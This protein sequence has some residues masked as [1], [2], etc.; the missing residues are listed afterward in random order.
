MKV[1]STARHV[2]HNKV[3]VI[4][5]E[6]Y[7]KIL[8]GWD[9]NKIYILIPLRLSTDVSKTDSIGPTLTPKD[10]QVFVSVITIRF[11]DVELRICSTIQKL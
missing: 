4:C 9:G 3:N 10:Q 8:Y 11:L 5:T 2:T 6:V 1:L 7:C